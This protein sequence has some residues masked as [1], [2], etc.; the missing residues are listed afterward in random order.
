VL[1]GA[2][3]P[4]K[5]PLPISPRSACVLCVGMARSEIW[6]TWT[7]RRCCGV[8]GQG[9]FSSLPVRHGQWHVHTVSLALAPHKTPLLISCP[10]TRHACCERGCMARARRQ[11]RLRMWQYAQCNGSGRLRARG[12]DRVHVEKFGFWGALLTIRW[13]L[14]R[15]Q[16][17]GV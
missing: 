9:G 10:R 14:N 17:V 5:T 13:F 6:E 11:N 12:R 16:G 3:A 15:E 7:C 4:P 1:G 2:L 8:H